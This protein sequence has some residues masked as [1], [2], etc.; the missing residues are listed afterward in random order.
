MNETF[1]TEEHQWIRVDGDIE[2]V[3]IS[4]FAQNQ[5]GEIVFVELPAV[6]RQ[7]VRN[8]EAAVVE[9]AKSANEVYCPVAGEVLESNAALDESPTLVN[10]GPEG[11]GWFFRI[12]VTDPAELSTLMDKTAYR[13]FS[14][15]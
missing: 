5:L 12:R 2:T 11:D 14:G 9:S 10:T 4:D 13:A 7:F 8:E 3:G 1:Y 6:G 15:I